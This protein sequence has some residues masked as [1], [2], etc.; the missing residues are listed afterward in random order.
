MRVPTGIIEITQLYGDPAPYV[1]DDGTI[2]PLWEARM[3]KVYLP[4]PL[5]LG[6]R[7]VVAVRSVRV[8]EAIAAEADLVFRAL[9]EAHL[10][11]HIATFDG[12]YCWRPMRGARK[13]SMHGFG[14][15][16]DFNAESNPL[17]VKGDMNERVVACFEDHGWTWGGRWTDRPDG[18]H[19]QY[20]RGY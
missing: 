8:N 7:P 5:P 19:F 3:T 6:W 11:D 18:Q 13:L 10:W 15:A 9:R 17:G 12:G 4:G 2:S 20:G 16:L 14:A 1:R